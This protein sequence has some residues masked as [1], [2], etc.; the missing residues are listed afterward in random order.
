[1]GADVPHVTISAA[2]LAGGERNQDRYAYGEGWAFV[3]DGASSFSR[4]KP[5]HDGG[6]YAERLMRA[7]SKGLSSG[8]SRSV[9]SVVSEAIQVTANAHGHDRDSCPTST[10]ALARW[11]KD[12]VETYVLGD[13]TAAAILQSGEEVLTD[14]RINA[15]ADHIREGYRSRLAAGHGFDE[16]HRESL[17]RL[18]MAQFEARNVPDGYWIA[19]ADPIAADHGLTAKYPRSS[20]QALV[21]AS[22]GAAAG[23][24]YGIFARWSQA[25]ERT[26][27]DVL[28]L[29]H[30]SE[31]MDPDALRWPRSKV[32]DD[33]TLVTILL[34]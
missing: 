4:A 20:T 15:I 19:G 21:L 28:G 23:M 5:E 1:M 32:H 25:L 17:V 22:D 24:R 29:V 26:P 31:E 10:I 13:T 11:D 30:S 2:T 6:W 14:T 16:R 12:H 18:Q 3:L 33:K 9:S 27:H 34:S 8:S 7:L